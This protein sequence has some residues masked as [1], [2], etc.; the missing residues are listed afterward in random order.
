MQDLVVPPDRQARFARNVGDCDVIDLDAAHM[1]MISQPAALAQ[2]INDIAG[3]SEA[4]H[5]G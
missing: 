2:I 5:S 3:G 4:L 1:C